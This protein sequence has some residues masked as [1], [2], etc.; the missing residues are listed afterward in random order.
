MCIQACITI[1][2]LDPSLLMIP[3]QTHNTSGIR[4]RISGWTIAR[5]HLRHNSCCNSMFSVWDDE[6]WNS[7]LYRRQWISISNCTQSSSVSL[8]FHP[9]YSPSYDRIAQISICTAT[10]LYTDYFWDTWVCILLL[11]DKLNEAQKQAILRTA[12]ACLRPEP[13]ICM[14]QG[15]PGKLGFG[16]WVWCELCTVQHWTKEN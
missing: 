16:C 4:V 11:Q 5:E 14:I 9:L 8:F 6:D 12:D 7:E 1:L 15:P 3:V 13:K 2:F 10:Y